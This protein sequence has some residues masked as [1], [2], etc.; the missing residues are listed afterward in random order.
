MAKIC[1]L[2]QNGF[3][4][5]TASGIN[6]SW[7]EVYIGGDRVYNIKAIFGNATSYI[8]NFGILTTDG[9]VYLAGGNNANSNCLGAIPI[10]ST[11]F[12]VSEVIMSEPI[13]DIFFCQWSTVSGGGVTYLKGASGR[14]FGCGSNYG[15]LSNYGSDQYDFTDL[16][17]AYV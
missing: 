9:K 5:G 4:L 15:I 6:A 16:K 2:T 14:I 12:G 10:A 8:G 11:V 13:E 3:G 1:G 7:Q 17:L